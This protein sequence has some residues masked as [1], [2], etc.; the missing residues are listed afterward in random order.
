MPAL[1]CLAGE[2]RGPPRARRSDSV[3]AVGWARL[4]LTP[5]E[6]SSVHAPARTAAA[7]RTATAPVPAAAG[8]AA[9]AVSS[10]ELLTLAETAELLR[11]S[12]QALYRWRRRGDGPPVITLPG[13]TVRIARSDLEDWLRGRQ[14]TSHAG[15][16]L[17]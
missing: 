7:A 6:G 8:D 3:T 2:A 16:E 12:R 14:M 13:G 4:G 17:S 9:S 11:V 1:L 10:G 15:E 5:P